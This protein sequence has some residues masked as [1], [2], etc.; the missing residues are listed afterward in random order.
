MKLLKPLES[1][2]ESPTSE[3]QQWFHLLQQLY[4]IT[5][6]I[7]PKGPPCDKTY[8]GSACEESGRFQERVHLLPYEKEFIVH[9]YGIDPSAFPLDEDS[10]YAVIERDNYCPFAFD[11]PDSFRPCTTRLFCNAREFRPLDCRFYP[12]TF[13]W[14]PVQDGQPPQ[15]MVC[16]TEELC[17]LTFGDLDKEW[18]D[19]TMQ[20]MKDLDEVLPQSWKDWYNEPALKFE[21]SLPDPVKEYAQWSSLTMP[22]K[23]TLYA[24]ENLPAY[25]AVPKYAI[26]FRDPTKEPWLEN[27]RSWCWYREAYP[28][29]ENRRVLP[30][31]GL[32]MLSY[33]TD[34][35]P[36]DGQ[37]DYRHY[38]CGEPELL[39][40]QLD[41]TVTFRVNHMPR[42]FEDALKEAGCTLIQREKTYYDP[43]LPE[44]VFGHF[45]LFEKL[46]HAGYAW[47]WASDYFNRL[48]LQEVEPPNIRV[49]SAFSISPESLF[50]KY[51]HL[52]QANAPDPLWGFDILMQRI[53]TLLQ[54]ADSF[55]S[56]PMRRKMNLLSVTGV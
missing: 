23:P 27:G 55:I 38:I 26:V 33:E 49:T 11:F 37:H 17:P 6:S 16:Y 18:V 7:G 45:E 19:T 34:N 42:L 14:P 2:L 47:R 3:K 31:S 25:E 35:P 21:E 39:T 29:P 10:G 53:I 30:S 13:H 41:G 15:G 9:R 52:V 8:C 40:T 12:L 20:L 32:P 56:D 43:V 46:V 44:A 54:L 24:I 48:G 36:P 28:E 1:T 4:D 50:R 22:F 5:S 51:P